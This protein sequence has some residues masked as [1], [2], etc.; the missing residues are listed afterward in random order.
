V[1]SVPKICAICHQPIKLDVDRYKDEDGNA[2]HQACFLH[3]IT[4]NA[5]R[6]ARPHGESKFDCFA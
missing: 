3:K 5:H 4:P 2:V 6:T 1:K